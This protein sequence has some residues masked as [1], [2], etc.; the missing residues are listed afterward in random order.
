MQR[1]FVIRTFSTGLALCS[2][3]ACAHGK[4]FTL[5][6]SER[7]I[8]VVGVGK[9]SAPPDIAR[10][11][12]GVEVRAADAQQAVNDA[13]TRMSAVSAAIKQLGIADKDLRTHSF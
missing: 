11:S 6:T 9:A 7:G 8:A 1:S 12:I 4:G 10:T 13:S 5:A 3:A 2:L